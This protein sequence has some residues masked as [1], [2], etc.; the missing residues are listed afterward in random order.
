[1]KRESRAPLIVA[2]IALA[3][4]VLYVASYCAMVTPA[5]VTVSSAG[6]YVVNN[7]RFGEDRAQRFFWP[8]EQIDRTLRP[9]AWLQ[10]DSWNTEHFRAAGRVGRG[11][12]EA[13]TGVIT[14]STVAKSFL[15][16][17]YV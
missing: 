7:Y 2:I 10:D 3:L 6:T 1:M 4:P 11:S 13:V 16:G 14:S 12:T 8:L 15:L 17:T 5:S 9:R